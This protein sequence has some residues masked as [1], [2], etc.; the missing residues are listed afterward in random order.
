MSQ[1]RVRTSRAAPGAAILMIILGVIALFEVNG[2]LG[3][4][5][6]VLGIGMYLF[7]RRVNSRRNLR[8]SDSSPRNTPAAT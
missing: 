3:T 7:N 6:V 2:L 8:R 4:V 1:V 5:L